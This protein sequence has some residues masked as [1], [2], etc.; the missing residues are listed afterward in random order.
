MAADDS[1]IE[2]LHPEREIAINGE[3]VTVR[4]FS[5]IDGLTVEAQAM[6]LIRSLDRAFAQSD[7][8]A[9][10]ETLAL[11][12]GAHSE[13]VT[14][15]LARACGRAEDWVRA[16]S[17]ADGQLLLLTFWGANAGFFGRRVA[18]RRLAREH[19]EA[20]QAR[21]PERSPV[22]ASGASTR[23]SSARATASPTSGDIPDAS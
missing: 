12:F 15:L 6:P 16:L 22:Q 5:F 3:T 8:G 19:V 10:L 18:A 11:V 9:S 21:A 1:D 13:Q 14:G 17:D 4:E 7:E 23:H 2:V 20:R